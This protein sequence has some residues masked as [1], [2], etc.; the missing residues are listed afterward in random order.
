MDVLGTR[1]MIVE[2]K[3]STDMES[4]LPKLAYVRL[5]LS[6]GKQR[7]LGLICNE[8][9]ITEQIDLSRYEQNLEGHDHVLTKSVDTRY[10]E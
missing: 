2:G 5:N 7:C 8:K 1:N 9:G 6:L 3:C 4:S 10:D